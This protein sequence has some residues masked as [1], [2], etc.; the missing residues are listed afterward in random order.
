MSKNIKS[1]NSRHRPKRNFIIY[2]EMNGIQ[3]V[4]GY[5]CGTWPWFTWWSYVFLENL[6]L[7]ILSKFYMNS[8]NWDFGWFIYKAFLEL[9]SSR[10]T[11]IFSK[12]NPTWLVT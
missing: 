2:G 9:S 1:I 7:T 5:N 10:T 11:G 8:S 6:E 12:K 4:I 3:N